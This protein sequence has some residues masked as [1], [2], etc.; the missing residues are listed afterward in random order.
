MANW[1]QEMGQWLDSLNPV[2][3]NIPDI[4][5]QF[6]EEFRSQY[7]DSQQQQRAHQKL[8]TLKMSG[9]ID[10]YN[11]EFEDQCQLA[12]YT[13][14]NEETVY[15]YLR[16]LPPWCQRDV[17]RLPTV[18][19]YPEIKQRAVDSAKAQQ[20]INSLQ[21]CNERFQNQNFQNAFRPPQLRPFFL[22]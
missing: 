14:G 2:L 11:A 1:A 17:L 16:G 6:Y 4:L 13:V 22:G 12:G 9:D 5:R 18:H 15:A 20:L 10:A 19:T 21:K 3:D 8:D 7:A